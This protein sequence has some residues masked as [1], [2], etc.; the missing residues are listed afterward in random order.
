MLGGWHNENDLEL[1]MLQ[2]TGKNKTNQ[3]LFLDYFNI[4]PNISLEK[5]RFIVVENDVDLEML[6]AIGKK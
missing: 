4:S 3:G 1:E 6:Q 5:Y 2:A